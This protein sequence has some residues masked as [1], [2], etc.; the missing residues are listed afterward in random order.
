MQYEYWQ[1]SGK[2]NS[3]SYAKTQSSRVQALFSSQSGEVGVFTLSHPVVSGEAY[4]SDETI[5]LTATA[6]RANSTLSRSTTLDL[7][8]VYSG[9]TN[10]C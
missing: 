7:P 4:L 3:I 9:F 6:T 5:T 10:K 1:S 2:G 8:L